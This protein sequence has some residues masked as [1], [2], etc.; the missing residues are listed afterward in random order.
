MSLVTSWLLCDYGEVLCLPPPPA[1]RAALESATRRHGPDFWDDYWVHRPAYDRADLTVEDY[2]A[3]VLGFRP[4]P[5]HLETLIA[6]D[7]A[8][9]LYPNADTLAATARAAQ[10]GFRLAVFSNAPIEVA[11]AIDRLDWLAAFS[12]RIYSCRLRSVKPEPAAYDAALLVLDA[13]AEDIVFLDDRPANVVAAR[14]RG[15][16]A[17]VFTDPAQI[18]AIDAR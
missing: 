3:L 11:A 9:W 16:R 17:E 18:D 6:V 10:R 13:R 14:R 15:I 12:P 5:A 8:N 7:T 1:D 2:W 4:P